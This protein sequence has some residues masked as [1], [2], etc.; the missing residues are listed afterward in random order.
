MTKQEIIEQVAERT[1][2]GLYDATQAVTATIQAITDAINRKED[3]TLRGFGTF[4]VVQAKA[5]SVRDINNGKQ[6]VL[7]S[8]KV[9]KFKPGK[10]LKKLY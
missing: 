10:E 3:V 2:M 1:D 9:V 4:K 8:R 6:Y 7:A 5:R